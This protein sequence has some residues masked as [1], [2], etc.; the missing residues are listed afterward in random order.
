[1]SR[2]SFY[3]VVNGLIE[4]TL[5]KLAKRIIVILENEKLRPGQE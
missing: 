5:K 1:M 3:T 2:F 4:S